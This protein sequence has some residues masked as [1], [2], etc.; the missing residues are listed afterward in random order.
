MPYI[1]PDE[2]K[3]PERV[4]PLSEALD[5][6]IEEIQVS[7][8]EIEVVAQCMTPEIEKRYE[9]LEAAQSRLMKLQAM[10]KDV[11]EKLDI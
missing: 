5:V 11:C 1:I 6:A 7:I 3:S 2:L 8:N 4:M 9:K 10:S